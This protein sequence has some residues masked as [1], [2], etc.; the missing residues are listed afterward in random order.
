M[1]EDDAV[2]VA[3]GTQRVDRTPQTRKAQPAA[4]R[5]TIDGHALCGR[6]GGGWHGAGTE[7]GRQRGRHG[8]AI[9]LAKEALQR[10]LA[11]GAGGGKAQGGLHGRVLA[12]SPLGDRQH[13]AVIGQQCRDREGQDRGQ[14]ID[15]ASGAARIRHLGEGGGQTGAR[16]R[17]RSKGWRRLHHGLLCGG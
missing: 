3:E 13:R 9:E 6:V 11:G 8:M 16:D 17:Q 5:F 7:A 2:L 4:L 12:R 14:G 1:G 15:D 10:R